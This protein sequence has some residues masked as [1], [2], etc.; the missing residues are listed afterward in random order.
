MKAL[1]VDLAKCNG[2]YNCQLAC[3]DEHCD[4]DWSPIA[5]PQPQTGQFWCKM[6]ERE[7]G[8]VPFVKVD[9]RP[10]FCG[11]CDDCKLLEMAPDCVYRNDEGFIVIDT[12]KAK[13]RKE[14]VD[15]CAEHLVF[16][17]EDLQLAQKCTGCSHLL[18]N[19]WSQPRCVDACPTGALRFG[20]EE[21]F[22][23]EIAQAQHLFGQGEG[24]HV[25]YLNVPKRAVAGIVANRAKGDV[26]IG[27]KVTISDAEGNEIA[28]TETNELGSFKYAELD[29]K[30]YKVKIEAEGYGST[31]LDADCTE[32]DVVFDDVF[33]DEL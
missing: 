15:A 9:Y 26:V 16:W 33:A 30:P 10:E 3:K 17:N 19:G 14:L 32:Q 24:S 25:Y 5:A 18:E 20:D 22:A 1:I 31:V 8:R 27:A 11:H 4:N 29:E 13:G 28:E 7:R 21:D 23:E 12:E 6:H 2:C